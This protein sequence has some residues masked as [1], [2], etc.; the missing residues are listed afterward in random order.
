MISIYIYTKLITLFGWLLI[1]ERELEP[2]VTVKVK[3]LCGHVHLASR[4]LI[5]GP[6]FES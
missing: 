3:S 2:L 5:M 1:Y 6:K 4:P